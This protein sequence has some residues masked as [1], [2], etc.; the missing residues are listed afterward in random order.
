MMDEKDIE[1]AEIGSQIVRYSGCEITYGRIKAKSP[2]GASL[3]VEWE[4]GRT[5]KLHHRNYGNVT[6]ADHRQRR[7][8]DEL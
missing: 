5:T 3:T 1:H 4:T 2:R 8:K 6:L 7:Q